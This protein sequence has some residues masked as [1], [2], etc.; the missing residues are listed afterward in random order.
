MSKKRLSIV[1]VTYNSEKIIKQC[2]DSIFQNNDISEG[3][4]VIVVDNSSENQDELFSM[5]NKNYFGKVVLIKN[6]KNGGYGQGNNVGIKA[7]TSPYIMIMNPDVTLHTPIFKAQIELFERNNKLG[8]IGLQQ[9][10]NDELFKNDSFI[11]KMPKLS[12][13][14]LLKI[15][16][17]LN[18]FNRHFFCFSGACFFIRKT[19]F[20]EAGWFDERIFLYGEE[21]DLQY[22]V[23]NRSRSNKLFYNKEHGYIHKQHNRDL[24]IKAHVEGFKSFLILGETQG[25]SRRRMGRVILRYY[26]QLSFLIGFKNRS[27]SEFYKSLTSELEQKIKAL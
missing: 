2:L 19:T 15:Y 20:D 18:V 8:I 17:K 7:S 3:L 27:V 12:Y 11:I 16:R 14:F 4:E 22:R 23:I 24:S 25:I 10:E 9:Y 1:I 21:S 6:D 13:L 26:K 5:L